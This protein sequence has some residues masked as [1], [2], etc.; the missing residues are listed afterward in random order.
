MFPFIQGGPLM[1]AVAAKAVAFGEAGGRS[2]PTYAQQV[3]ANAQALAE[4]LAAEGM[5]PVSGG[6][7]THL[8]LD[9]PARPGGDRGE[10]ERRCAAAG[11]TLNRNA[12]PYDRSR[13]R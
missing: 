10:A 5:R 1:H 13:R 6:T 4:A 11:I 7:D 2:S 3:V 9:R 8:A 12:I